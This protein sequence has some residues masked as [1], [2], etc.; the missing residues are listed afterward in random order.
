MWQQLLCKLAALLC[1]SGADVQSGSLAG[2]FDVKGREKIFHVWTGTPRETTICRQVHFA[3]Y[4][5]LNALQSALVRLQRQR[6]SWN[7]AA[8]CR[9]LRLRLLSK[10]RRR[11]WM[12]NSSAWYLVESLYSPIKI[13]CGQAAGTCKAGP[14]HLIGPLLERGS[15]CFQLLYKYLICAIATVWSVLLIHSLYHQGRIEEETGIFFFF[16]PCKFSD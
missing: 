15:E 2:P 1:N 11:A 5:P 3:Q 13:Q 14:H 16:S 8:D 10:D 4:V 12:T 7:V 6:L 9:N